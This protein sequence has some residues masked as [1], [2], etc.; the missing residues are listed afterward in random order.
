[1]T[2]PLLA[3]FHLRLFS[4]IPLI[5]AFSELLLGISDSMNSLHFYKAAS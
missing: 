4:K 2:K 5:N 3:M 1:M